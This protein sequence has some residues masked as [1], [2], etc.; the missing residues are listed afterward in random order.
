MVVTLIKPNTH[1]EKE[2]IMSSNLNTQNETIRKFVFEIRLEYCY[3]AK[4]LNHISDCLA[5]LDLMHSHVHE[6]FE[7]RGLNFQMRFLFELK[8]Y[9]IKYLSM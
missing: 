2:K 7:Q 4:P 9:R 8:S 3:F 6:I 5:T 1:K